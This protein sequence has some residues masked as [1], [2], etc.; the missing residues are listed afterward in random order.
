M[1]NYFCTLYCIVLYL[2]LTTEVKAQRNWGIKY[3]GVSLHP[4]GDVNAP[5]M[6]LNPDKKG[7]LVFNLGAMV[8]YEQFFKPHKFSFKGIQ[9]VYTDCAAQL[10]GFTHLGIR[11]VVFQTRR[12][13]LNGGIGPTFIYRRNWH[14]LPGYKNSGY[15]EGKPD[16]TWQYKFI[17]YA[18]E[19]EYNYMLTQNTDFSITFVPGYPDLMSLSFGLRIWLAKESGKRSIDKEL[20]VSLWP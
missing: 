15:F 8:S 3:F 20:P 14:R 7:Y 18:G 13:S 1:K 2:G 10:A 11:A 19:F 4:N 9:A 6:P 12:H 16:A 5:L 17:P